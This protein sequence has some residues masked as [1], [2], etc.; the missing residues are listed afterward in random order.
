[1]KYSLMDHAKKLIA[2]RQ[3]CNKWIKETLVYP[4]RIQSD[5]NDPGWVHVLRLIAER[6]FRVLRIIYNETNDPV[7]IVTAYFDDEVKDL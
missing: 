2:K 1:M 7:T 3:I 4:A 6:G 5:W